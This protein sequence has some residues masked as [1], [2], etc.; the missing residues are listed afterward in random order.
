MAGFKLPREEK[1]Q[2]LIF[3]GCHGKTTFWIYAKEFKRGARV[4]IDFGRGMI[5]WFADC[6]AK[7]K[8]LF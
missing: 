7:H 3:G 4:K 8:N 5:Y 2:K 6:A 1:N